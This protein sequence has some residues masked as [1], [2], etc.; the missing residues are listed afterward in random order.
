MDQIQPLVQNSDPN[1]LIIGNENLKQ[2][3]RHNVRLNY[4]DYKIISGTYT[5]LGAGANFVNDAISQS[6]TI[7][8]DGRTER[9][10]INVDGNYSGWLYGG[11]GKTFQ[12]LNLRV[13]LGVSTNTSHIT[14]YING[15]KNES[16]NNSYSLSIPINYDKEKVCNISY[17]PS[18]S[19]SQ[20]T[21][22]INTN[23]TNYWS[24]EHNFDGSV[25]LPLKFQ[26]GTEVQWYIRQRVAQFDRNNDEFLWNAYVSK[27]FL[28]NNQL[29]LRAY[30]NDILNQNIGFQRLGNG[31]II[32]EQQ[33]NTIK[34]YGMLSL[35]WNFTKA[36]G[37]T[38]NTGSGII[39]ND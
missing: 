31:N 34:R 35:I 37:G 29:E 38:P 18:V 27:K 11:Y 13:G 10:Y 5:Y 26:I 39:I 24:F 15:T 33:Y 25:E 3:F 8:L 9:Q 21:A 16:S 20:N 17:R 4:N 36:Q 6:Q 32:T 22:T 1:N 14:N 19:Y 12:K 23:T 7:S 30:V 2:E 28:K